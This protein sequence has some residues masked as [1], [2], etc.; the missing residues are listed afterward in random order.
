MSVDA[1]SPAILFVDGSAFLPPFAISA[2]FV[3]RFQ[4]FSVPA[5]GNLPFHRALKKEN[6]FFHFPILTV[7][8]FRLDGI[9]AGRFVPLHHGKNEADLVSVGCSLGG[10]GKGMLY[11]AANGAGG[12]FLQF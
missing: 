10:A 7:D 2:D 12:I 8:F 3:P 11:T 4:K 6:T 1:F 5:V 9:I